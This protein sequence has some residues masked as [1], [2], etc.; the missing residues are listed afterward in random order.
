MIRQNQD[1]NGRPRKTVTLKLDVKDATLLSKL[2]NTESI[3]I[4][5]ANWSEECSESR[6]SSIKSLYKTAR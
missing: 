2:V 1:K 3:D 6:L 4:I 5:L